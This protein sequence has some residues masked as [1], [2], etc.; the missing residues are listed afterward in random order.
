MFNLAAEPVKAWSLK[1]D[2]EI[3]HKG[4]KNIYVKIFYHFVSWKLRKL[5]WCKFLDFVLTVNSQ[6]DGIYNRVKLRTEVS[7]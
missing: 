5:W 3:Y 4:T 6:G 1:F 2:I 7:P